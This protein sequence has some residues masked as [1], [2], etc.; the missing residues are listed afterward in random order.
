M[1]KTTTSIV[2]HSLRI[3]SIE[4][5]Y[6]HCRLHAAN[7]SMNSMTIYY[8]RFCKWG[9]RGQFFWLF[10]NCQNESYLYCYRRHTLVNLFSSTYALLNILL[11]ENYERLW[12]WNENYLPILIKFRFFKAILAVAKC[13]LLIKLK[14]IICAHK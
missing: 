12:S 7:K 1:V 14:K 6:S 2:I 13:E 9:K 8:P 11:Q 10:L 3:F 5:R 4:S